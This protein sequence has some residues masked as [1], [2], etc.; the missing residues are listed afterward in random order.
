MKS[1]ITNTMLS[2]R[3]KQGQLPTNGLAIS[4]AIRNPGIN[5]VS[6]SWRS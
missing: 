1:T 2:L 4:I 3:A 5:G 6:E